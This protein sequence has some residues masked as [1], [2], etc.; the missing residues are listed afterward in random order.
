MRKIT[1][2]CCALC[3]LDQVSNDTPIMSL[4]W[5]LE[6]LK[7][8]KEANTEV[9]VTTGNGQTATFTVVSPGEDQLEANLISL[10]YT[11]VWEF[12]RRKGYPKEGNLKLYIKNL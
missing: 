10:G 11:K 3:Q 4:E 5:S 7:R 6:V 9:G 2:G 12:E 1:T 8:Q